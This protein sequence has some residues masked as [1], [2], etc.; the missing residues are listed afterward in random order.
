MEVINGPWQ[1][2]EA[3]RRQAKE[4]VDWI[5][6]A[7]S[8]SA[9]NAYCPAEETTMTLEELRAICDEAGDRGIPVA[10]HAESAHSIVR[11][12]QAGVQT[13]EHGVFLDE[14]GLDAMVEHDVALCPTLASYRALAAADPSGGVPA[15]IINRNRAFGER[16]VEAIRKAYQAGVRLVAGSD[17]GGMGFPQGSNVQEICAF[18]ELLGMSEHEALMSATC[19]AADIIGLG[20]EV[21]AIEAGRWADLVLLEDN[22]LTRIRVLAE[23]DSYSAVLKG[24]EVVGGHLLWR[25]GGARRVQSPAAREESPS[26]LPAL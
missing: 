15:E 25:D 5:K 3:V 4:G 2:R 13:I 9:F 8:G 11:A 23:E 20:N 17:G 12:A 18:V 26:V 16:H 6:V 24:G 10:C 7:A 19:E 14:H 21:G 22:P 1:A